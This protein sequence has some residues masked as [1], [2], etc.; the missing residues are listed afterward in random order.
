MPNWSESMQQTYEFYQVDP[1]TWKDKTRLA[2]VKSCTI[3][4]DAEADTLGS[5]SFDIDGSVGECYIRVYLIT[6]QNGVTEKHPLGTF[7]VQT[8]SSTLYINYI[9]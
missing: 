7:I 8:P 1:A 2:T 3:E 5:A 9:T 6:I 4:R